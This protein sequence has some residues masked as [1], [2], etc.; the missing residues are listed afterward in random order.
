MPTLAP[1][2]TQRLPSKSTVMFSFIGVSV[3]LATS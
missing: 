1:V 2:T 3:G